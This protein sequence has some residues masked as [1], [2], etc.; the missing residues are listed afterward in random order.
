MEQ[1]GILN[2]ILCA[3]SGRS[4]FVAFIAGAAALA[5][6]IM[7]ITGE[8]KGHM[9]WGIKIAFAVSGLIF[10]GPLLNKLFKLSIGC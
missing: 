7:M 5:F 10:L 6:L 9:S 8:D 2:Q 3:I 4:P 1:F